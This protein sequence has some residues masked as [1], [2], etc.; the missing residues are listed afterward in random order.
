MKTES[1]QINKNLT[2]HMFGGMMMPSAYRKHEK[3][4]PP[5]LFETIIEKRDFA[6][7]F[8]SCLYARALPKY[9]NDVYSNVFILC[10]R[11]TYMSFHLLLLRRSYCLLQF[12]QFMEMILLLPH[13]LAM[14]WSL[15]RASIACNRAHQHMW[16]TEYEIIPHRIR[17][18]KQMI[19]TSYL[20]KIFASKK[21]NSS[22]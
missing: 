5:S 19:W 12:G 4:K 17:C 18:D 9:D 2:I 16:T 7:F 10:V 21:W 13:L 22:S 1:Q 20:P 14:F 3:H 6:S 15:W 8:F 11:C